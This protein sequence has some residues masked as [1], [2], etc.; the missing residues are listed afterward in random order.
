MHAYKVP[1]NDNIP[2]AIFIK[3]SKALVPYLG[4]LY[5]A[6]FALAIYPQEWKD[7][8]TVVLWKPGKPNYTMPG[9]YQPIALIQTIGKILSSCIADELMQLSEKHQLL[10]ANHFGC[11]AG[12]STSDSLHYVTKTAKD[13]MSKGKVISALFLDIKGTFPSVNLDRLIHDMHKHGVPVDYTD[14]IL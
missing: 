6:T 12:H 9:A 5:Q 14:W 3:C 11:R 13:A 1:G 10:P 2:N 4:H 7:S 8:Q